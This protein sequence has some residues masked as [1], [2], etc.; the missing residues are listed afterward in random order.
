MRRGIPLQSIVTLPNRSTDWHTAYAGVIG[1]LH[2]WQPERAHKRTPSSGPYKRAQDSCSIHAVDSILPEYEVEPV[3]VPRP[4]V[5]Q[6]SSR[7]CRPSTLLQRTNHE[8]RET[9][10][11][12]VKSGLL[13][14]KLLVVDATLSP[15]DDVRVTEWNFC[16]MFSF[17]CRAAQLTPCD[18]SSSLTTL[19][20][21]RR[22]V[23]TRI[24]SRSASWVEKRTVDCWLL[25]LPPQ[26]TTESSMEPY[27]SRYLF[28]SQSETRFKVSVVCRYL[29]CYL[30]SK[31]PSLHCS[32]STQPPKKLL[33]FVMMSLVTKWVNF[34]TKSLFGLVH[35]F[36][37]DLK[38]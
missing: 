13:R 14:I 22:R 33:P 27:Y 11:A 29:S 31:M 35:N 28:Y 12:S 2:L 17:S 26:R 36:F 19:L 34:Q 1:P 24:L 9:W 30:F 15:P 3:P 37:K 32:C 25:R 21:R 23:F 8:A 20:Q 18:A 4:A 38:I 6:H 16:S 5:R 7:Q 10:D